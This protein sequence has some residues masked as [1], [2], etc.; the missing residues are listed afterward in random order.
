MQKLF[1]P[2]FV[3]MMPL[4]QQR[5]SFFRAVFVCKHI[6]PLPVLRLKYQLKRQWQQGRHGQGFA[7]KKMFAKKRK[8][9]AKCVDTVQLMC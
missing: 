7:G 6:A 2:I 9:V 1:Q 8:K 4:L 5:H 3:L